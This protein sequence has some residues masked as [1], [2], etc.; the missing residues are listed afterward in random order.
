MACLVGQGYQTS[1]IDLIFPDIAEITTKWTKFA[2][3]NLIEN[4]ARS[5][6][7]IIDPG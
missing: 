2:L 6:I 3:L 7:V 5:K 1:S 4:E